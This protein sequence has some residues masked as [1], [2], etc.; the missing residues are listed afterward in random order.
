MSAATKPTL[1]SAARIRE[2]ALEDYAQ[3]AALQGRN[4]MNPKSREEWLHLWVN[5]PVYKKLANWTIGWVAE[6]ANQEIV[7]YIGNI[8]LSFEYKGREIL[9][10]SIHA[11]MTDGP[12][13]G[14][15]GFLLRRFLN[16]KIPELMVTT[17]ANA[18]SAKL[19]HAFRQPR[20]PT[21]DWSRSVFWITN[22]QGFLVSVLKN[23]G[24]PR[25]LSYPA[26]AVLKLRDKLVNADSWTRRSRREIGTCSSFDE[27]FDLF[28]EDLKCAY[29]ERLLATRSREVLQWHFKYALE[30]KRA[31]IVTA[32]NGSGLLAYAIFCR[33]DNPEHALTRVRLVDFQALTGDMEVLV[34]MLA[35]GLIQCQKEGIHM[36]EAFGFRPEKQSVIDRLAPHRR[37]F[38][39]WWY[40]YKTVNKALGPEL[41]NPAVWDPSHFDGDATL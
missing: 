10:A 27:R 21:G 32:D 13:R 41:Q 38:P 22:Y 7:G 37:Q 20:V 39:N 16:Y 35:S 36:L 6:N 40:F 33:Q 29:P 11:L 1:A 8:P 3:V 23:K 12:H 9:A 30:Q 17:T 14:S 25:V 24:L 19:N 18:N 2:A 5:N 15:A 26:S 4:D 34:A 31:W 28:W